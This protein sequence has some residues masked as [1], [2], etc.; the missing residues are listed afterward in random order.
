MKSCGSLWKKT[1]KKG[2]GMLSG[3]VDM[4]ALGKI[5]IMVFVNNDKTEKL[6][7][8]AEGAERLP[9]FFISVNDGQEKEEEKPKQEGKDA[10]Q[11]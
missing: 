5:N 10:F 8:H 7:K 1:S 11:V 9:D 6:S 2:N 4:G 3:F